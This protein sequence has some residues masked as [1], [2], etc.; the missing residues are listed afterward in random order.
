MKKEYM[1][2]TENGKLQLETADISKEELFRIGVIVQPHGVR[3]EVKVLPMTDDPGR[4]KKL[5]EIYL[6]DGNHFYPLHP[7][8]VKFQKQFIIVKFTEFASMNDV[9]RLRKL[10]LFVTRKDTVKCQKDEYL[11]PDLI[12]LKVVDEEGN[13][14]G[15]LRDVLQ[16][17]AND[18]YFIQRDNGEELLLP[19]IKQCILDVSISKGQMKVHVLEGL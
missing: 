7:E 16:T 6:Q 11:I 18:V 8:G 2:K 1:M 4:I 9:E 15:E 19:A 3:G 14:V 5:K 13:S 12:G 10:E 17:G